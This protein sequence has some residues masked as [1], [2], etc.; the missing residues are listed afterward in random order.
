M[1]TLSVEKIL[2][3]GHCELPLNA[4]RSLLTFTALSHPVSF[5]QERKGVK[6]VINKIMVRADRWKAY[7]NLKNMII[8]V[9]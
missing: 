3:C 8:N 5:S 4:K 9:R 6:Q 7:G 1:K 2:L